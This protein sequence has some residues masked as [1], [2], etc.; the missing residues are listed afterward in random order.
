MPKS[1]FN[2]MGLS[3]RGFDNAQYR[4]T[5][6][7]YE[8]YPSL[9]FDLIGLMEDLDRTVVVSYNVP[10]EEALGILKGGVGLK[11]WKNYNTFMIEIGY[12]NS[13]TIVNIEISKDGK[14]KIWES[15]K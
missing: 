11:G 7:I 5:Y 13:K 2:E 1:V 14:F 4:I 15:A 10:L 3:K 12:G 9:N 6:A 8:I